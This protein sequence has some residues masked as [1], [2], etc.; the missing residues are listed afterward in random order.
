MNRNLLCGLLF[1]IMCLLGTNAVYSQKIINYT[2]G[3]GTRDANNPDVWV[4][5]QGVRAE[6]DGMVLFADSALMNTVDNHFRAYKDVQIVLSDTTRIWGDSLYYDGESRVAKIWSD[7]VVLVDG[8]TTLLSPVMTYDRYANTATYQQW[9]Y[10]YNNGRSLVSKNGRYNSETNVFFIYNDVVL[11]DSS[12]VVLTDTLYYNSETT[13]ATIV[14]PTHI[15]QDSTYIYSEEGSYNSNEGIA[16]SKKAS[17][18]VSGKRSLDCDV[19]H[20]YEKREFGQAWGHVVI[21]DSLNEITCYGNYGQTNQQLRESMVTDSALVKIVDN[22]DTVWVHADTLFVV[23]DSANNVQNMRAFHSV[24]MYRKDAQGM[25]DSIYYTAADSILNM[26]GTPVLWSENYQCTAD[27][28]SVKHGNNTIDTTWFRCSP[29]MIE[30]VD[31][32]KFNQLKG[33]RGVAVFKEGEPDY[34][35]ILGNAQMVYYV[36]DEDTLGRKSLIGVNVGVGADMRIYLKNRE[37]QRVVSYSN[38]D[39]H[40]YPLKSLPKEYEQLPGFKWLGDRRPLK[41]TDV[42]IW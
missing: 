26:Y 19:L 12:S 8:A 18:L 23:N 35:D 21:V 3:M 25:C 11:Q 20:Y 32:S 14:C 30:Q 36:L 15:Y 17:H 9:G 7:T 22:G 42:F 41:P 16:I 37:P 6:H 40:T 1:M 29:M 38:P 2:S 13:E 28:I 4:L 31:K 27:T 33:K 10:G 24:K 5:F 39:M 34:V